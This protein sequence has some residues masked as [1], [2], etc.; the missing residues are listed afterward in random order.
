MFKLLVLSSYH[1]VQRFTTQYKIGQNPP[2][3]TSP[4]NNVSSINGP[5]C[6]IRL[7]VI[8][9]CTLGHI[10]AAAKGVEHLAASTYATL[11]AHC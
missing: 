3:G 5:Q 8:V 7:V 10:H 6:G 11:G 9:A 4:T 2:G 1:K